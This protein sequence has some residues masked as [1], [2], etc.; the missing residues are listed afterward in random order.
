MTIEQ[1][2]EKYP[3]RIVNI[4]T[5]EGTIEVGRWIE[6]ENTFDGMYQKLWGIG[7]NGLTFRDTNS[8]YIR[9]VQELKDIISVFEWHHENIMYLPLIK[10][11]NV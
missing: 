5:N 3:H 7:R 8:F 10:N 2:K 6:C 9:D 11:W 1:Y 4:D